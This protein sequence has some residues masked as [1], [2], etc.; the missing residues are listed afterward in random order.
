MSQTYPILFI[1]EKIENTIRELSLSDVDLRKKLLNA[2]LKNLIV[3]YNIDQ[4]SELRVQYIHIMTALY[5]GVNFPDSIDDIKDEEVQRIVEMIFAY[6]NSFQKI[7]Y[8]IT[9]D[10]M[11]SAQVETVKFYEQGFGRINSN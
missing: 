10:E 11:T 9:K 5:S 4:P 3:L 1:F 8:Q 7:C 6:S 2:A